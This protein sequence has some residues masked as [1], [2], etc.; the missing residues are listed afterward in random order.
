[1][2]VGKEDIISCF[3]VDYQ[4]V[5]G[6]VHQHNWGLPVAGFYG[7]YEIPIEGFPCCLT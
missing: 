3:L 4:A 2:C 1:M 6:P 7:F 5:H